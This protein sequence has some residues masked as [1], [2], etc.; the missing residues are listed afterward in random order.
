[1]AITDPRDV[2]HSQPV[3]A[4]AGGPLLILA[5]AL[6]AVATV[7]V[8]MQKQIGTDAFAPALGTLFFLLAALA[9]L[10]AWRRPRPDQRFTYWDVAG[11]LTLLGILVCASVEPEQMVRLVAG[12]NRAS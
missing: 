12:A 1:M 2:S 10:I 8:A 7:S 6:A 9:A 5:G 11:L 4:A 3:A